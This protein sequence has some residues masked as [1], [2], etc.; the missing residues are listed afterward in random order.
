MHKRKVLVVTVVRRSSSSSSNSSNFLF[1]STL[2]EKPD[3]QLHFQ[4]EHTKEYTNKSTTAKHKKMKH[5]PD[6][7]NNDN[8]NSTGYFIQTA[9]HI[10]Q[11][12]TVLLYLFA[13]RL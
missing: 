8:N 10:T 11:K 9:G 7:T 6:N 12:Q 2:T 3:G 1:T 4:H 5:T 13:A